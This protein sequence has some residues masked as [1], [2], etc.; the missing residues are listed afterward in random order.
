MNEVRARDKYVTASGLTANPITT[1]A[2]LCDVSKAHLFD[3][4]YGL[5]FVSYIKLGEYCA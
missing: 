2:G 3:I 4:I 1:E 5:W